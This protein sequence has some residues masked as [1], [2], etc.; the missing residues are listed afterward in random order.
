MPW[1]ALTVCTGDRQKQRT[2]GELLRKI[3]MSGSFMFKPGIFD[4]AYSNGDIYNSPGYMF[5][6]PSRR[7][8]RLTTSIPLIIIRPRHLKRAYWFWGAASYNK[9]K[10][11]ICATNVKQ[12]RSKFSPTTTL[13]W[14]AWWL[15]PVCPFLFRAVKLTANTTG[16]GAI[17][18][19]SHISAS[20]ITQAFTI[21][22]L[23][24]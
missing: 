10:L 15:R 23:W 17:W 21:Y 14:R 11:F 7:S 18:V 19:T 5:L 1:P 16:T 20:T 4:K 24:K 8:C 2:S 22:C 6:M 12:N 13:P 3:A 9:K